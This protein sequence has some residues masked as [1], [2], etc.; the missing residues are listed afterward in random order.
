MQLHQLAKQAEIKVIFD[1]NSLLR[2][3]NGSWNPENAQQ[4]LR[5]SQQH[6]LEVDWE[7][8]NGLY[9]LIEF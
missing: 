3:E 6:E 8:G 2:F 4:M 7:L 9:H 1:L 5:F